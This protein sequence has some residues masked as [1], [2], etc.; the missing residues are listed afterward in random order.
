MQEHVMAKRISVS[1]LYP[2]E[3]VIIHYTRTFLANWILWSNL[4]GM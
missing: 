1:G 3:R 4:C 2:Y